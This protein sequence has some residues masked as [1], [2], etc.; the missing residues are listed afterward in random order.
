VTN[1]NRVKSTGTFTIDTRRE[2]TNTIYEK[3]DNIPGVDIIPGLM[4]KV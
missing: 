3:R 1:P 2:G 4:T